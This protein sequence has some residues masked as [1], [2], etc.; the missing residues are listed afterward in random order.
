MGEVAKEIQDAMEAARARSQAVSGSTPG[1]S[2]DRQRTLRYGC[3]WHRSDDC[4]FHIIYEY[5]KENTVSAI[6]KSKPGKLKR[7]LNRKFP[8]LKSQ[9]KVSSVIFAHVYFD[10]CMM[11]LN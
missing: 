9:H 6:S 1:S 8:K 3:R 5:A 11:L 4:F 7:I 2:I 10:L